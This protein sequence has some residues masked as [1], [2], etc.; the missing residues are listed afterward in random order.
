MSALVEARGL[1]KD[2]RKSGSRFRFLSPSD[3]AALERGPA[4]N[5]VDLTI[6]TGEVLGLV[7][8]SGSGKSTV[9]RLILRLLNYDEGTV[10]FAG[11]NLEQLSGEELRRVRREM[12][13]V[14]Q[15]P[16][17]SLNP[18]IRVGPAIR[19]PLDIFGLKDSAAARNEAVRELMRDVELPFDLYDR[20]PHQLSGGQRQRVGIARALATGP[21][22]IVADEPISNLDVSIQAQILNLFAKLRAERGLTLLFIAHDLA[23]VRHICD[24]VAV[25]K[26]GKVV[27]M[28]ATDQ[29]F[30]QPAHPYTQELLAAIPRPPV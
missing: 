23:T 17:A 7:G 18:R 22:L 25:M 14:F 24:R 19:E 20:D 15:D 27:E 6:R 4:V 1:V 21:K 13:M 28:G 11:K 12:Q 9:G 26:D 2:F 29:I 5:G 8:E 3:P 10:K 30:E 16:L